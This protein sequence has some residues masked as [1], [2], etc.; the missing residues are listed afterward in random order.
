VK[1]PLAPG[2]GEPPVELP[3][4]GAL[5]VQRKSQK[6]VYSGGAGARAAKPARKGFSVLE[7]K[8][9]SGE[10][11]EAEEG[12]R[13][14]L[15]NRLGTYADRIVQTD[16]YGRYAVRLPDGDWTVKVTMPSGRTYAVRQLVIANG[17]ISDDQGVDIPSLVITR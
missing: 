11:R 4:P 17:Q 15:S 1:P 13:V 7:G 3:E 14:T 9:V 2:G 8:V 5:E 12:V 16:A 6:P 10:S